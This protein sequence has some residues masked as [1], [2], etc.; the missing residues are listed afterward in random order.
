MSS[1][2]DLLAAAVEALPAVPGTVSGLL[3]ALAVVGLV[4]VFKLGGVRFSGRGVEL[5]GQTRSSWEVLAGLAVLA[6]LVATA[7][8]WAP[9]VFFL[10]G[11]QAFGAVCLEVGWLVQSAA[12]GID[13]AAVV[14]AVLGLALLVLPWAV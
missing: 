14:M 8:W 10:T 12:D 9:F 4:Y 3:H 6:V 5:F 7:R 2:T 13:L 1:H 11:W